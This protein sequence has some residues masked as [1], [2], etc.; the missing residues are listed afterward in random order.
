MKADQML[1]GKL[2]NQL[3]LDRGTEPWMQGCLGFSPISPTNSLC[4]LQVVTVPFCV[5]VSPDEK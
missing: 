4:N 5:T 2:T 3:V 1:F